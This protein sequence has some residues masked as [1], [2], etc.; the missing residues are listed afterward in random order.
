MKGFDSQ[1]EGSF[2]N[3]Y[4]SL[5]ILLPKL[6]EN[7]SDKILALSDTGHFKEST[8]REKSLGYRQSRL[9]ESKPNDH[10]EI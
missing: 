2:S 6:F 9:G 5:K 3:Y 8:Q 1:I 4:A 10:H 7:T